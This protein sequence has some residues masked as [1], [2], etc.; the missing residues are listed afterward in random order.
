MKKLK[1]KNFYLIIGIFTGLLVSSCEK[2][3]DIKELEVK[4]GVYFL[5]GDKMPYT[6]KINT[7]Y[8]SG[9]DSLIA[10]VEEGKLNGLFL[11]FYESGQIIDSFEYKMGTVISKKSFTEDGKLMCD[12]NEIEW[13]KKKGIY[14]N[15]STGE[16]YDGGC[17][18]YYDNGQKKIQQYFKGGEK[19]KTDQT[20]Y[21]SGAKKTILTIKNGKKVKDEGWFENGQTA[22][23]IN[24][25]TD[26]KNIHEQEWYENG[27]K[28]YDYSAESNKEWYENGQKKYEHVFAGNHNKIKSL[29]GWY[30]N[31]KDAYHFESSNKIYIT[32]QIYTGSLQ[33]SFN[34]VFKYADYLINAKGSIKDKSG[35]V[36]VEA[37]LKGEFKVRLKTIRWERSSM[38]EYLLNEELIDVSTIIYM[39]PLYN[40]YEGGIVGARLYNGS[41]IY[42]NYNERGNVKTLKEAVNNGYFNPNE[43]RNYLNTGTYTFVKL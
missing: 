13:D 43:D 29:N 22:F 19:Y 31:G 37:L 14:R 26:G 20:W 36:L 2:K 9:A 34:N 41:D 27:N 5:I 11:T 32:A 6:G 15:I 35:N 18:S 7:M 40:K 4:E 3:V 8:S 12:C 1:L 24:Y 38:D 28:K 10:F 21:E 23:I 42:V 16:V 33:K 17:V 30:E 25:D 39:D